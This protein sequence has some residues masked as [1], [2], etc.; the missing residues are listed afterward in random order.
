MPTTDKMSRR[1]AVSRIAAAT[2]ATCGLSRQTSA[3]DYR[4]QDQAK[5]TKAAARYQDQP[6]SNQSCA[7]CPYFVIPNGCAVV[8]GD[9]SPNG[10]CPMYTQFSPMDRGAHL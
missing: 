7:S 8:L 2:I 4:P 9:V 6:R 5:L 3:Q 10:W 1:A